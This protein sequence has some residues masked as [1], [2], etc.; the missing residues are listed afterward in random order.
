[1]EKPALV[2]LAA[3]MGSRYGGLKQMDEFGP[4]G[5]NIID[6]SIYAAIKAGF[7]KI[8]FVIRESFKEDFREF[9]SGKFDHLVDVEFV[10]QELSMLP[11]GYELPAEREKPWGTG[12]AVLVTRDAV[13]GPFAVINADDFYGREAYEHLVRF[14]NDQS[15]AD[16]YCVIGYYLSNTLSDHGTVNRG[17]C[18]VDDE[19]NL[20]RVEE[21]VKIARDENGVIKFP[22]EGGGEGQLADDT[23]VSMNIWGFRPSYYEYADKAFREFLDQNITVPKSELYI[24][25]VVDEL[26]NGKVLDVAVIPSGSSWFGVTYK[27]DKPFVMEQLTQLI[28]N[29]AYPRNLWESV[30]DI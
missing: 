18:V 26:I 19:K 16:D 13:K 1:M 8:V 12:H 27:D 3:G 4:N 21:V 30:K 14:F 24:P 23:V 10:T 29:G 22:K 9:F 5:E 25:A 17:V 28:D 15:H 11:D 20:E 7:G 2:V 6:Y